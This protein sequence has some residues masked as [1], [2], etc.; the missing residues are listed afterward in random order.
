MI[1]NIVKAQTR[2]LRS[3]RSTTTID[4]SHDFNFNLQFCFDIFRG[5][6]KYITVDE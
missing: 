2:S 6:F 5:I 1:A 3:I 4:L